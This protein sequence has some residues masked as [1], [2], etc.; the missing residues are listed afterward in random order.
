MEYR[1]L[2]RSGLKVSALSFGSMTFGNPIDAATSREL[3]TVARDAGVNFIDSA[4]A[5]AGGRSE[6]ICRPAWR[7]GDERERDSRPIDLS[8]VLDICLL[9]NPGVGVRPLPE[10][11]SRTSSSEGGLIHE[12][13]ERA[14]IHETLAR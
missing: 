1:R 13:S 5:Y 3:L 10:R 7:S 14:L 12:T 8:C 6:E 2:G 9:N 4:E 11:A